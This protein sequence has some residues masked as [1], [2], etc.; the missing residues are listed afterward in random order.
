MALDL[1]SGPSFSSGYY[2][3][4][5]LHNHSQNFNIAHLNCQSI[6]PTSNYSKIDELRSFVNHSFLDVFAVT[7]TWLKP[8][9]SSQSVE[10]PGFGFCRNDRLATRGGGVGIYISSKIRYKQVFK[11][12]DVGVCESLFVELCFNDSVFLIGVVYLPHGDIGS[13]E[14]F[15]HNLFSSYLNIIVVGDFNCNM[16]DIAKSCA[17]RSICHRCN[18][19]LVHNSRPSHFDIAHGSTSL[20][21]FWLVSDISSVYLSDQMLCPSISHHVL[22]FCSFYIR[23]ERVNE[24]YEYRDFNLINWDELHLRLSNFDFSQF[25]SGDVDYQCSSISNLTNLLFS[26]VPI[27][28]KRIRYDDVDWMNSSN[29]RLALSLRDL[30]YRAYLS[31]RSLC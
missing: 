31:N 28:R 5:V 25:F 23:A 4:S 17:M 14:S 22:L 27:V 29:I 12:S 11:I 30:S 26:C 2:M 6:K 20:I 3:R 1:S 18:L 24:Y 19:S 8:D 13:F 15:H 7:E 10:I 16:F 9:V 21:D